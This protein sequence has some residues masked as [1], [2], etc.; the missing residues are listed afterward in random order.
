[1]SFMT[2]C[3]MPQVGHKWLFVTVVVATST[4]PDAVPLQQVMECH[5]TVCHAG[6]REDRIKHLEQEL[7]PC[8]EGISKLEAVN[9]S[10]STIEE[11]NLY[12]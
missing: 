12:K 5:V 7:K 4:V 2:V 1:M 10:S 9:G 3:G 6:Q 11:D 8:T